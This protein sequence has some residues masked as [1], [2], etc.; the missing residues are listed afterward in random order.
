MRALSGPELLK[1]KEYP[2]NLLPLFRL[3]TKMNH[4]FCIPVTLTPLDNFPLT[5]SIEDNGIF[6]WFVGEKRLDH[7]L[8][9]P[10]NITPWIEPARK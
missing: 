6:L 7:S 10:L 4:I 8:P 3:Q 5:V 2:I 9:R 1:D